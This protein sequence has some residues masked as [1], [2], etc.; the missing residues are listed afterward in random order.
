MRGRLKRGVDRE[1][2]RSQE[3]L[4]WT[5]RTKVTTRVAVQKLNNQAFRDWR[6]QPEGKAM[7]HIALRR[8]RGQRAQ[9]SCPQH[10]VKQQGYTEEQELGPREYF[11]F[12]FKFVA[13][14]D[15]QR[16]CM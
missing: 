8:R 3:I 1:K 4:N 9:S 12:P 14:K 7:A 15:Q 10:R 2:I 6:K 11:D 13:S 5:L 16:L